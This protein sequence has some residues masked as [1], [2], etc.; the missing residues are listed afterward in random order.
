MCGRR[1]ARPA[2]SPRW[3]ISSCRAITPRDGPSNLLTQPMSP[4]VKY[5]KGRSTK[6]TADYEQFRALLAAAVAVYLLPQNVRTARNS[7]DG[8]T[9]GV[10]ASA[11]GRKT[12]AST[13]DGRITSTKESCRENTQG[14]E[15]KPRAE[16]GEVGFEKGAM[17]ELDEFVDVRAFSR[18]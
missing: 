2:T 17:E 3:A 12:A 1:H 18:S 11:R 8:K 13:P 10:K 9:R 15:A 4:K 14:V 7:D 6:E 16:V 5:E